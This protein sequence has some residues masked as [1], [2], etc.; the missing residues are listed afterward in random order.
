MM[1]FAVPGPPQNLRVTFN[2]QICSDVFL[3][4]DP[5]AMDERNGEN[6]GEYMQVKN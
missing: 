1:P 3:R 6:D 5:P 4:W 2:P